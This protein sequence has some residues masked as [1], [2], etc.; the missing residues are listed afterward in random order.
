MSKAII[1]FFQPSI[2]EW[3]EAAGTDVDLN[4]FRTEDFGK[5]GRLEILYQTIALPYERPESFPARELKE[6]SP[7]FVKILEERG[8]DLCAIRLVPVRPELPKLRQRGLTILDCYENWFLKQDI[9]LDEYTAFVCP[10][11]ETLLWSATFV[12]NEEAIF[13]EI[14]E[15][16]HSELTHGD[17]KST[18][19]KFRFDFQ[20]W[21]WS[22][23]NSEA[24]KRIEQMLALMC[25]ENE[26]VQNNLRSTLNAKFSHDYIQG[27]FE[28]TVWPKGNIYIIDYNRLLPSFIPTPAP[29][30]ESLSHDLKGY[31]VYPG[32]V[33][34]RVVKVRAESIAAVDFE[35]GAIL[36]CDNT[37]VRYLPLMKRA[38]AIITDRGGI[39]SHAAI[40]ARELKKPCI[41]AAKIGMQVLMDGD[42]VEV[43]ADHGTVRIIEKA[44]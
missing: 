25:V 35:E 44:K 41:V 18:V 7:A 39:L 28:A 5:I 10:H 16:L 3:F 22:E 30:V 31:A 38:G 36:V 37:D 9:N 32:V 33:V 1:T 29:F 21:Q 26:D 14:V 20:N 17:T 42:L 2:T 15:G 12:V 43:N 8:N 6:K 27:Y 40:V 23:E 19:Y 11:S 13:G 24:K 34:G 4:A